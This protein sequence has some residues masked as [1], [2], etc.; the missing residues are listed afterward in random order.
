MNKFLNALLLLV[1]TLCISMLYSCNDDDTTVIIDNGGEP[2]AENFT[3]T[4]EENPVPDQIIGSISAN[5]NNNE[6]LSFTILSQT[7]QGS[8]A[9][10]GSTGEIAV[11]DARVFDYEI[12]QQVIAE[13]IVSNSIS[14]D[15]INVQIDIEDAG[16]F[17]STWVTLVEDQSITIPIN[18]AFTDYNYVV[19]W[20]DGVIERFT[21][22]ADHVFANGGDHQ[23][24]ISGDFPAIYFN[25]GMDQPT[26]NERRFKSIDGWGGMK[27]KSFENAFTGCVNLIYKADDTP[28]L[29]DVASLKS[30]FSNSSFNGDIDDWD[31]SNVEDFSSMF[32]S[33]SNWNMS[34]SSWDV[35]NAKNMSS[36][37][38]NTSQFNQP[39]NNWD[40]SGV[41]D[42]SSMFSRASAFDQ[43]LEDWDISNVSTMDRMF[44]DSGMSSTNY[45]LTL[46]GWSALPS[47]MPDVILGAEGVKYCSSQTSRT[48]LIA[49][50][51]TF[52]GDSV[53]GSCVK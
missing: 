52:F 24:V 47:V 19:N 51:W 22:A 10:D 13:V 41:T 16:E 2:I 32:V 25:G 38:F 17:V 7:P 42:M 1:I 20:G 11:G 36:M 46:E 28:D 39:L 40:V 8:I 23:I 43:S 26:S 12:N 9:I 31:V 29:S 45:D 34:I 21:G 3:K 44:N 15:T 33:V 18:P 35:S 53:D 27:W 37:F 4:V 5:L 50:G 6:T 49:K 14:Q 30:M 48:D